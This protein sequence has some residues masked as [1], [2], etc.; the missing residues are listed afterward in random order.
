MGCHCQKVRYSYSESMTVSSHRQR[1]KSGSEKREDE[2]SCLRT[3]PS[4]QMICVRRGI[5]GDD[6]AKR[7]IATFREN[8]G[9]DWHSKLES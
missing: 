9:Y 6:M 2:N 5:I 7:A 3:G 4:E 1:R 8:H